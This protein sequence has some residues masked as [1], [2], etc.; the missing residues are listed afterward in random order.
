MKFF[1]TDCAIIMEMQMDERVKG[2]SEWK[3]IGVQMVRKGR[4]EQHLCTQ[5]CYEGTQCPAVIHV[6]TPLLPYPSSIHSLFLIDQQQQQQ[7][8]SFCIICLRVRATQCSVIVKSIYVYFS[9]CTNSL[10][11]SN[12]FY[13]NSCSCK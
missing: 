4:M 8:P 5:F 11:R 2:I 10:P 6:V 7:N 9:Y 13:S 12:L 3:M 1:E